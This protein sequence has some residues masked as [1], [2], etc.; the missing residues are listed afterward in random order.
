MSINESNLTRTFKHA[1]VEVLK[2]QLWIVKMVQNG[3][4]QDGLPD[5]LGCYQ[6]RAFGIEAKYIRNIPKNKTTRMFP[7]PIFTLGQKFVLNAINAA[8][9]MSFGLLFIKD[10]KVGVLFNHL[11]I[12]TV[13]TY[14]A[15]EFLQWLEVKKSTSFPKRLSTFELKSAFET[16]VRLFPK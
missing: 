1:M 15:G 8:G 2:P 6:G 3:M 10:L 12:S 16:A 7:G 14:T 11:E 4:M 5:L 9:G 13:E